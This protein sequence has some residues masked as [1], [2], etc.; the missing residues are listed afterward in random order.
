MFSAE[1]ECE[2]STSDP[3]SL[4]YKLPLH[5]RSLAED[6]RSVVARN[7]W[8]FIYNERAALG[9]RGVTSEGRLLCG[10]EGQ[11]TVMAP[12][13]VEGESPDDAREL[14]RLGQRSSADLPGPDVILRRPGRS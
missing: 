5:T 4:H 8:A 9:A 3:C 14:G 13:L 6:R 7:Q 2:G 12:H 11:V 10:S 1:R